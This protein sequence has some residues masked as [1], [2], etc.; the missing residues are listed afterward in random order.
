VNAGDVLVLH[1]V[2]SGGA[3]TT[4]SGW[5]EAHRETALSNPKG[6]VWVKVAD[7]TETGNLSVTVGSTTGNAMIHRYSGVDPFSPIDG[8][9]TT[10]LNS[11]TTLDS[12]MAAITTSAPNAMLIYVNGA[13][14]GTTRTNV[15]YPGATERFDFGQTGG[16]GT[17]A[18]G[19]YDEPI[20]ASGDA[21]P[22]TI[23]LEASRANW[24]VYFALREDVPSVPT[25]YLETFDDN[26]SGIWTPTVGGAGT[27][28][29]STAANN[30]SIYGASANVP[31]A[32]GDKAGYVTTFE[33]VQQVTIQGWWK[34]TT[35][36][37]SSGSN[38]PFAR[39][40]KGSQRLADV[41]RQ[42]VVGGAN[43]WLR[44]T[45]ADLSGYWFI[46]SGFTLPLD[47]W[48]Y[49]SFTWGL[50]GIPYLYVDGTLGVD[51]SDAPADW[52]LASDIDT[53][54]LG[55][56]EAGNQGAWAA[57]AITLST[58]PSVTTPV[59]ALGATGQFSGSGEMDGSAQTPGFL[60]AGAL[61]GSGAL[62]S[63]RSVEVS[64]SAS[65]SGSGA[66]TGTA[67]PAFDIVANT[68]GSGTLVGGGVTPAITVD[69]ALSGSGTLSPDIVVEV[70]SSASLSGS[71]S[72]TGSASADNSV[73]A[74]L[75]GSG[76]LSGIATPDITASASMS[77]S[78]TLTA[79]TP[80]DYATSADFSGS[81]T[82]S[83]SR[84]AHFAVSVNLTGSGSLVG[85]NT[86]LNAKVTMPGSGSG[87]LSSSVV[88]NRFVASSLSS[89]GT[90]STA[91]KAG[92]RASMNASGAG[93]L[94]ASLEASRSVIAAFG[95]SGTLTIELSD[96]ENI[97]VAGSLGA[98]RW[99]ADLGSKR[100]E[101]SL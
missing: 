14:S 28:A 70:S 40:F 7:G 13:N 35:E 6:G 101:G 47:T 54:Y 34:V 74:D 27:T 81:G 12:T 36:G 60:V 69:S 55:T 37:A 21:G 75:S 68:S 98:K 92:A 88:V 3:A 91:V 61:G 100:W 1:M 32:T 19:F 94:S 80:G 62:S 46:P 48:V 79:E 76:T 52:Y 51:G 64:A 31:A 59:L 97:E 85:Y 78:G 96:R 53:A 44:V 33:G 71:G 89:S 17:K 39:I 87:T 56:H 22:R 84:V 67:V 5:T 29:V 73:N 8:A 49:V 99:S 43:V 10:V 58:Y 83:S 45:K 90:L 38:V 93:A 86:S 66:L 77:G 20:A 15:S 18:G 42:N 25:H 26:D 63:T 50:D 16:T 4:P 95:G 24:G 30:G 82:L 65:F 11:A 41:Y 57:D 9:I 23:N 2:T 72:L